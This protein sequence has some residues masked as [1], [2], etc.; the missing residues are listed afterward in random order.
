MSHLAELQH[1]HVLC[2]LDNHH[3]STCS[4]SA[5][6]AIS[7]VT[8]NGKANVL[9]DQDLTK[10]IISSCYIR[11]ASCERSVHSS[12]SMWQG[13]VR[14]LRVRFGAPALMSALPPTVLSVVAFVQSVE[15]ATE[16]KR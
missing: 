2:L 1:A 10:Q 15:L 7:H 11:A 8:Q 13:R 14:R 9:K 12:T 5:S 4:R 3:M 16:T 6:H